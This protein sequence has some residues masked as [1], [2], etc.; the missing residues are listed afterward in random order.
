MQINRKVQSTL[1]VR[2]TETG[3]LTVTGPGTWGTVS[4]TGTET[5]TRTES[6]TETSTV[7]ESGRGVQKLKYKITTR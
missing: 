1:N 6:N 7:T 3:I 2:E 4:V 5:V